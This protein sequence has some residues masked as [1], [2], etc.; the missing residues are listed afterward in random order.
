MLWVKAGAV[1]S[2]S[3]PL[4]FII[5]G[6][7]VERWMSTVIYEAIETTIIHPNNP[8]LLAPD[9][10][11]N[12]RTSTHG[13]RKKSPLIIRNVIN[14]V[15]VT[16]GWGTVSAFE[17]IDEKTTHPA[18]ID[19]IDLQQTLEIDGQHITNVE[20]LILPPIHAANPT[21]ANSLAE[22]LNPHGEE[23]V[24]GHTLPSPTASEASQNDSD[25][26]IR[27][28]SREGIVEMEVR[29]PP[30]AL[31]DI[32]ETIP[33]SPNQRHVASPIPIRDAEARLYHRV[34]LLS[35]EPSQMIGAICKSQIVGWVM[36]PLKLITLRLVAAHYL[37][38]N[39]GHIGLHP[40]LAPWPGFGDLSIRHICALLSRIA[41]CG[42]LEVA[43]DLGLWSTQWVTVTWVGK[44]YFGW[45]TL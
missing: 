43:I 18:R 35:A 1:A 39:P 29:L 33:G 40:V 17:G 24:P 15:L 7:F 16:F 8:D 5:F 9:D 6:H 38:S 22:P 44:N 12:Y 36:M 28:T 41:L 23:V 31:I 26:R 25:P 30:S 21:E 32:S 27:I 19:E 14:D 42:A 2:L 37:A 11:A 20:R 10:S 45:G 4:A 13:L 3:S 34:T